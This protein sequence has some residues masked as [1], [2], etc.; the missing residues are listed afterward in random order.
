MQ[1]QPFV[2]PG[3]G[4]SSWLIASGNEAV[5]V[6][7]Q[8]DVRRFLD[9]ADRRGWRITHVL[10]THCHNDY[11]SGAHEV[12]A[13]TG[14]ELV[15]P[16][17]G[18]YTFAHRPADEGSVVALGDLQLVAMA[19]PGH[20]PEHLAWQVI[21]DS[22]GVPTAILTGGSLLAGS[23]GR[24]DLLGAGE[25]DRL[26]KA[27]HLT[28]RRLAALPD[29]VRILPTH[30]SGSFCSAGP[31]RVERETSIGEE[32]HTNPL[33]SAL[34]PDTFRATL[35]GGLGR[36]PAYFRHMAPINRVGATLLADKRR[37]D[38]LG[39]DVVAGLMAAGVV[40]VDARDRWSHAEAHIPGSIHVEGT[41]AFASW[42]GAVVPFGSSIVIVPPEGPAAVVEELA[43]HLSRIG[44]DAVLGWLDGGIDAWSS[45]GRPVRSLPAIPAR[46]L[47]D[48]FDEGKRPAIL[49]VRQPT[50]WREGI[51]PD[52]TTVFVGDLPGVIERLDHDVEWT[53]ICRSGARAS[54]AGSLLARHGLRARVVATGGVPDL[55]AGRVAWS[56]V[57]TREARTIRG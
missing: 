1:I 21:E 57:G 38:P 10:E 37:P 27:Q 44:Y 39:A 5:L 41:D 24:T 56:A 42:V 16:A 32:R 3:L 54:I 34:D 29:R 19:T 33:L 43:M 17:R 15:L 22:S 51:L 23:A 46:E 18:G 11:V 48:E 2:T 28:L 30:G 35:L 8:R 9:A 13:A 12:R 36:V 20:T 6:D 26:T 4:N 49:D 55:L 7:P 14:A 52:S 50:E 45:S 25:L 31:P 47:A 40:V 53:V